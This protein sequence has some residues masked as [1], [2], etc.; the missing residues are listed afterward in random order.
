MSTEQAAAAQ[1]SAK[2]SNVKLNALREIEEK[3]QAKWE[4]EKIFEENAPD[5]KSYDLVFLI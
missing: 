5:S 1:P 3:I 4:N 2:K